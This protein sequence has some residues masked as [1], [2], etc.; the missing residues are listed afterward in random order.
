MYSEK[1]IYKIKETIIEKIANGRSL[2]S[3]LNNEKNMPSR[4]IIYEWLNEENNKFDK[5]FLNNYTRAT[6]DRADVLVDEIINISDNQEKDVYIDDD[7]KEQINHNVI[8]RDKL[9]VDSRKW[10]AGKMKPKKY[11]DSSLLKIADNVGDKFKIN[12][13]FSKDLL[14]VP[15][16]DSIKKDS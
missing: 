11:G 9:R 5:Q 13:I 2:L 1:Q 12:A 14:Y 10:V 4:P 16:H 6:Q 8:T 7:G 3:V 15:T